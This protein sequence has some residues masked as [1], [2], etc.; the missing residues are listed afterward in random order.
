M[1][2]QQGRMLLCN[3]PPALRAWSLFLW[4]L[5]SFPISPPC[6]MRKHTFPDDSEE[7]SSRAG[8]FSQWDLPY[9]LL[10]P[11]HTALHYKLSHHVE[12]WVWLGKRKRY[13]WIC[14]YMLRMHRILLSAPLAQ[15]ILHACSPNHLS[16][17]SQ[18]VG[19]M[20]Q[21]IQLSRTSPVHCYLPMLDGKS[22]VTP[23]WVN[24]KGLQWLSDHLC[25]PDI[26]IT[27]M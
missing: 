17:F 1:F 2:L 21:V 27:V 26:L 24:T 9:T 13:L 11:S 25:V 19:V 8:M 20:V 23:A 14:S 7:S 15:P 6:D 4:F 12:S 18:G 16:P 22:C 5:L 10:P 3:I